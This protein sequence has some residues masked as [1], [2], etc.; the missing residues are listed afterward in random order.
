MTIVFD[1]DDDSRN[2][3]SR[4]PKI[5]SLPARNINQTMPD[6]VLD[7]AQIEDRAP[8][9]NATDG[10][11]TAIVEWRLPYGYSAADIKGY[12]N[13]AAYP[14]D[15]L[16]PEG[17]LPLP[18]PVIL[19]LSDTSQIVAC[20]VLLFFFASV[21]LRASVRGRKFLLPPEPVCATSSRLTD[22]KH[23]VPEPADT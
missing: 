2:D 20:Y 6:F 17:A 21:T 23:C 5:V 11:V 10:T 22:T 18:K 3:S 13:P 15:C 7:T 4:Q 9:Y 8:V 16:T 12:A 1:D 14:I 19:S